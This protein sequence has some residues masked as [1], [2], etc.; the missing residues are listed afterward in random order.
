MDAPAKTPA[1]VSC[2]WLAQRLDQPDITILDASWRLPGTSDHPAYTDYLKRHIKGALFFDIDTIADQNTSLPHMAPSE[3]QFCEAMSDFGTLPTDHIIIYDDAG[4]FSAPRVWWTLR[5]MGHRNV[6]VLNGGL[7]KWQDDHLPLSDQ[8]IRKPRTHYTLSTNN[9]INNHVLANDTLSNH[10]EPPNQ[11]AGFLTAHDVFEA[12]DSDIKILDAR[13]KARFDGEAPEPRPHL[14]RGH[15][16]GALN[17]PFAT[18]LNED[19]TL[20][21]VSALRQ[22][23]D[24]LNIDETTPLITTCGSGIS[25]AVINLAIEQLGYHQAGLYDGAWAE[26]GQPEPTDADRTGADRTD[27]DSQDG[28]FPVEQ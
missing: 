6:S 20:K 14:R 28:L 16:P 1:L 21:P 22:I 7:V 18:L 25:A 13:P 23:F 15:M 19:K 11:Q 2:Q 3:A 5:T 10:Q 26:W 9:P 8:I 17:L 4:I 27:A 12:L 24:A